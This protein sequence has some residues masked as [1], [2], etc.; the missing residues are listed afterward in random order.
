MKTILALLAALL[1]PALVQAQEPQTP[2]SH[3]PKSEGST[4]IVT[5]APVARSNGTATRPSLLEV[6]ARIRKI[7]EA[8]EQAMAAEKHTPVKTS[9]VK[10]AADR[11]TPHAAALA[12]SVRPAPRVGL[13]WRISLVWPPELHEPS[14]SAPAARGGQ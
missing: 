11:K 8:H 6:A 14:E 5:A 4:V 12:R 3:A 9:A 10:A 1:A 2:V 13:V 7:V